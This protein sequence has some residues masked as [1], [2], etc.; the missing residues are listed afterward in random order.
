MAKINLTRKSEFKNALRKYT[1]LVDGN[2]VGSI[3]NGKS[4]Q[5]DIEPGMHTIQAKIDWCT[6]NTIEFDTENDELIEF[7]VCSSS[8]GA[9]WNTFFNSSNFL[10]LNKKDVKNSNKT[11]IKELSIRDIKFLIFDPL[12]DQD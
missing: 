6:S 11:S 9:I 1:I 10:S 12:N 7:E 2:D 8:G 5:I 4:L 3:G